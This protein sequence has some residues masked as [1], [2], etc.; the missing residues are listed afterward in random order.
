MEQ[1]L[2][3]FFKIDTRR[4]KIITKD[5]L[6]KYAEENDYEDTMPE[7][8]MTLFD[9]Q[10]TGQITLLAFCDKLGLSP[11][12]QRIKQWESESIKPQ[13]VTPIEKSAPPLPSPQPTPEPLAP[14]SNPAPTS[15]ATSPKMDREQLPQTVEVVFAQ[16]PEPMKASI[17]EVA[18][19]LLKT[20][21]KTEK[22]D[23]EKVS[24][25]LKSQ[26]DDQY[27]AMWNVAIVQGSYWI[28]HTHQR[29]RTFHFRLGDLT[30]IAWQNKPGRKSVQTF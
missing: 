13:V 26:L 29:Q 5:D 10:K 20:G 3:T 16:M 7:T 17:Y 9:P 14:Q 15:P 18:Q 1:L 12:C 8:W 4:S 28:T 24:L 6:M 19:G 30:V 21:P 25:K 22:A 11:D 27:G 2:E 23:L